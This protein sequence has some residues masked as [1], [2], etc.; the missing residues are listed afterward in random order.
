MG[1]FPHGFEF[2]EFRTVNVFSVVRLVVFL[3]LGDSFELL[4]NL[5]VVAS[6]LG[7]S[8]VLEVLLEGLKDLADSK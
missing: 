1:F 6:A 5:L 4:N 2:F 8:S 7:S 3:D